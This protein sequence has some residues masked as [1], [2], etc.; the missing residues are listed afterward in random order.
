[1]GRSLFRSVAKHLS[2]QGTAGQ[3]YLRGGDA[4]LQAREN[5]VR[6]FEIGFIKSIHHQPEYC[7]V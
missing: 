3:D 4:S 5:S 1:M 6:R 2:E 7:S